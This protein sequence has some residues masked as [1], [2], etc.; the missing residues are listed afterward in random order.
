LVAT[1]L[2]PGHAGYFETAMVLAIRP[3]LVN[4]ETL[5][6]VKDL[7]RERAGLFAPLAGATIQRYGA[8]AAGPGY[9]DNPAAATAKK[10]QAILEVVVKSVAD[11]LVA[12]HQAA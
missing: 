9:T 1:E 8:W 4:P 10:G 2:I 11:F 12:F 5:K 6:G 3:D 7:S